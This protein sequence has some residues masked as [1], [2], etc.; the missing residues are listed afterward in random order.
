[1]SATPVNE[2]WSAS[3]TPRLR[4]PQRRLLSRLDGLPAGIIWTGAT[5]EGAG[6]SC[7][8]SDH[9]APDCYYCKG[10]RGTGDRADAQC[11]VR[12]GIGAFLR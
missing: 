7:Y 4:C 2:L 10:Q 9:P 12:K 1:M 3:P 5:P 8:H 6:Q 11:Y